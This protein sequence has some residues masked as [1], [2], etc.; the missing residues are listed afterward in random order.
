MLYTPQKNM[1]KDVPKNQKSPDDFAI[2]FDS[3]AFILN[4]PVLTKWYHIPEPAGNIFPKKE[5]IKYA[6]YPVYSRIFDI[7]SCAHHDF[8]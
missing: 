2:A 4:M 8:L 3:K 5:T 1:P 7:R 6:A